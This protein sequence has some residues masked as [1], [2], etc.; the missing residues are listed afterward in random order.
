MDNALLMQNEVLVCF[1]QRPSPKLSDAARQCSFVLFRSAIQ[2]VVGFEFWTIKTNDDLSVVA[3]RIE[4]DEAFGIRTKQI[5]LDA[6]PARARN[7]DEPVCSD[8][9]L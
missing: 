6:V 3:P 2:A 5:Y 1:V 4:D 8:E 7:R 9:L